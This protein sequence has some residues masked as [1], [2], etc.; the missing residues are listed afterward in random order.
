MEIQIVRADG[1]W[2]IQITKNKSTNFIVLNRDQMEDL[3]NMIGY[4]IYTE[5]QGEKTIAEQLY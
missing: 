5:A 2:E 3:Y 1:I 4:E